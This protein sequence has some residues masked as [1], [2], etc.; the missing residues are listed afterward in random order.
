MD[1]LHRTTLD[2]VTSAHT[3]NYPVD[4]WIHGPDLSA[5]AGTPRR[6][7]HVDGDSVRLKT[8]QEWDSTNLDDYKAERHAAIDDKTRQLIS[9]GFSFGGKTFSLSNSAQNNW[10]ALQS[11]SDQSRLTFPVAVSTIDGGEFSIADAA[12]MLLFSGTSLAT[13]KAHY[14]SGRALRLQVTAATTKAGVDA[15]ADDR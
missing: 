6:D 9:A 4:D 11:S 15:V 3:P 2:L 10:Q 5:V 7:W 8:S 1:V 13:G 12:Q 14:D